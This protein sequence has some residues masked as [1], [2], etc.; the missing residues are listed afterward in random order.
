[1]TVAW[2]DVGRQSALAEARIEAHRVFDRIWKDG[3]LSRS[4]AYQWLAM[5]RGE[6]T[7]MLDL[8]EA[9]CANVIG[10]VRAFFGEN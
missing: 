1:M 3:Y 4:Q 2:S 8:D 9:G 5:E 6:V 7:H 10:L